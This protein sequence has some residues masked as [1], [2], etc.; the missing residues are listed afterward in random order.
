MAYIVMAYIVM[1]SAA[2]CSLQ[3][4]LEAKTCDADLS[5]LV[6]QEEFLNLYIAST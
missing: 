6:S 1:A 5:N 2:L 3:L 4:C